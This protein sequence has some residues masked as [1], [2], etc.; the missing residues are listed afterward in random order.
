MATT[1]EKVSKFLSAIT[2][3]AEEQKH[4]ILD[5]VEA[6]KRN[7]LDKAESEVLQ[8]AYRLIQKETAEMRGNI[9]REMSGR[10]M[11]SRRALL[12]KRQKITDEVFSRAKEKLIA[13]TKSPGYAAYMEKSAGEIMKKLP[14]KDL[15]LYV[16]ESDL[17]FRDALQKTLNQ[18]CEVKADD[19]I[20]IGGLKGV[21]L[22]RNLI[23]DN[24]LDEKLHDRR[25]WFALNSGLSVA[26]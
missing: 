23:A 13:F 25:E 2:S 5:E 3:Y 22:E 1:D 4:S 8:G 24:S 10:E 7:E 12:T 18:P 21:S 26:N 15:V 16:K 19:S 6:Y 17:S 11:D 14:G 9:S 20:E